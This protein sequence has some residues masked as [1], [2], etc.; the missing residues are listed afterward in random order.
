MFWDEYHPSDKA[1]EL[2]AN[3]LI[4]KFGFSRVNQNGAPSPAPEAEADPAPAPA[5]DPSPSPF[6]SPSPQ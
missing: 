5:A 3:E 1:N 2:I 6:I 4:K